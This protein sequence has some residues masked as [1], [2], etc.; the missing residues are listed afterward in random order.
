MLLLYPQIIGLLGKSCTRFTCR[1]ATYPVDKTIRSLSKLGPDVMLACSLPEKK[2]PLV[3]FTCY[4]KYNFLWSILLRPEN[5][6]IKCS[7][8]GSGTNSIPPINFCA[9]SLDK[10]RHEVANRTAAI[11]NRDQIEDFLSKLQT[12]NRKRRPVYS[13]EFAVSSP[14]LRLRVTF[15]LCIMGF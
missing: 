11:N 8:L 4:C 9:L 15:Y 10:T 14:G 6:A 5:D 12:V 1:I 3:Q 2:N 13:S 7:K